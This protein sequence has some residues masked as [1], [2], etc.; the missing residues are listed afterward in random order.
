MLFT[1]L[2][3]SS[4]VPP[5]EG[6]LTFI[7]QLHALSV[8]LCVNPKVP[9]ITG[10]K[11]STAYLFRGSCKKWSCPVCGARNGKRWLARLLH[12][13]N[14]TKTNGKWYFLTITAHR[15]MR[16]QEASLK[17][18]REGW[19]KLY[20]RMLRKFGISEY[21]K[22]WEKHKDGSFHLHVLIRKKISKKWLK[23][24]AV[25]CGM[26]YQVDSSK[27]KN[28]G[29]VAGYIAKYLLKSF[30][31]AIDFPKGLRRIE[32]S[33]NWMKLP[34][35]LESDLEW[36][37]HRKREDQDHYAKFLKLER[38]FSIKDFRGSIEREDRII[39]EAIERFSQ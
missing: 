2:S 32:V 31:T 29:M 34:E 39:R 28:E 17:N 10:E 27:S 6:G 20:N 18:L 11:D 24:N 30:E 22:V 16:G 8:Q 36:T 26:G 35:L 15:K 3:M 4:L 13:M 19:K 33:H 21:C 25:Q 9:Y 5:R 1:G 14:E 38:K 7:E 12:H 23:D 37:I